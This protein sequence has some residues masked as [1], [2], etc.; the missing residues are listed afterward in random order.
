L[1]DNK[2]GVK[3]IADMTDYLILKYS[4]FIYWR[5]IRN[6]LL[7]FVSCTDVGGFSFSHIFKLKRLWAFIFTEKKCCRSAQN[8]I[9]PVF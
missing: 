2:I 5:T 9:Q 4:V 6:S 7:F 8:E 3:L 1:N